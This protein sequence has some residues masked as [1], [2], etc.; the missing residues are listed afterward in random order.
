MKRG[1][2]DRA[3]DSRF[4]GRWAIGFEQLPIAIVYNQLF[5]FYRKIM[6]QNIR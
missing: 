1:A 4:T 2:R 5:D 3:G 6:I